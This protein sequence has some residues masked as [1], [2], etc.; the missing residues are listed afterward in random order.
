MRQYH[1]EQDRHFRALVDVVA[2]WPEYRA[3]IACSMLGL[4]VATCDSF[5]VDVEGWLAQLRAQQPK[6]AVLV[7]PKEKQS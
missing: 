2:K 1:A 6:P 5:G 7:P 4:A 3:H